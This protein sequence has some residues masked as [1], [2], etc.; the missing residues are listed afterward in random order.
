M[1]I[2]PRVIHPDKGT[3]CRIYDRCIK[4]FTFVRAAGCFLL[5]LLENAVFCVKKRHIIEVVI[6]YR[7]STDGRYGKNHEGYGI[8][9]IYFFVWEEKWKRKRF[10][11]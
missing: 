4:L 9:A 2:Y 11:A 1:T 10:F 7:I 5:L 8:K 3:P 6:N